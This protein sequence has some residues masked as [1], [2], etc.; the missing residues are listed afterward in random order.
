MGYIRE[1]TGRCGPCSRGPNPPLIPQPCTV[2]GELRRKVGNG[3]CRNCWQR[4]PGRPFR[5]VENLIVELAD[6]SAWLRDFTEF[7]TQRHCAA[8][9]CVMLTTIGRLLTDGGPSHPQA[10]LERSRLSGRSAGSL[11]RTLEEFFVGRGLAFGLDQPA[12]LAKGRRDRRVSAVP[13]PLRPLV[14]EYAADLVSAQQRARRIGT[15][16]RSDTTIE[17]SLTVVR[18]FAAFLTSQRHKSDW[19]TVAV[20]DV[21]AFLGLQ[22]SNRSGRLG[23]L[24]VFFRFARRRKVVLVDPTAGVPLTKRAPFKGAVLTTTEQRRLFRRWTSEDDDV[25]PNEAVVGV[26]CLLHAASN[27]EVRALKVQ[28]VDWRRR[29]LRLGQ[30]PH[31]V[32]I[33]PVTE[34]VLRRA[35]DHRRSLGT[36]NPHLIVTRATKA[37]SCPAS[38]PYVTHVLDGAGVRTKRLRQTRVLDLVNSLDPKMAAE[39]LGMNADGLAAYVRDDVTSLF[40]LPERVE[41]G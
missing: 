8:R 15:H 1:A 14:A 3:L 16:A 41:S 27:A 2:C 34:R 5:R 24:R 20:G 17:S 35:L 40:S 21:E 32:P 23:R 9:V 25:E 6:Q 37:R 26:L 12:R 31:P 29:T 10:V 38:A 7:A 39:A 13:D 22:P 11:A 18:D 19:S 4:D 28:D 30:R 33:D 36:Q